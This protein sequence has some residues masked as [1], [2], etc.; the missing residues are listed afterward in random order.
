MLS[1]DDE[2]ESGGEEWKSV[3]DDSINGSDHHEQKKKIHRSDDD[4][5][6]FM[7]NYNRDQ[8]QQ[9]RKNKEDEDDDDENLDLEDEVNGNFSNILE[10][11]DNELDEEGEGEP[12]DGGEDDE[13][14]YE[15]TP[16]KSLSADDLLAMIDSNPIKNREESRSAESG[17]R[18]ASYSFDTEES[19]T[20]DSYRHR[21][22]KHSKKPKVRI[23]SDE[24][25]ESQRKRFDSEE[26]S[27]PRYRLESF[28]NPFSFDDL[29]VTLSK[30][31]PRR[32]KDVFDLD[33]DDDDDSFSFRSRKKD[34]G[35]IDSGDGIYS[36]PSDDENESRRNSVLSPQQQSTVRIP[37]VATTNETKTVPIMTVETTET[38]G[39]KTSSK[40][41]PAKPSSTVPAPLAPSVPT[42]NYFGNDEDTNSNLFPEVDHQPKITLTNSLKSLQKA[43]SV[44]VPA[45]AL[46]T[47]TTSSPSVGVSASVGVGNSNTEIERGRTESDKS[48]GRVGSDKENET[49]SPFVTTSF[50]SSHSSSITP[51]PFTHPRSTTSLSQHSPPS[52]LSD[53]II[54]DEVSSSTQQHTT[55]TSIPKGKPSPL[56]VMASQRFQNKKS[57]STKPIFTKFTEVH[58]FANAVKIVPNSEGGALVLCATADSTVR[59][60]DAVSGRILGMYEGHSDRV[61]AV[62]I[63]EKIPDHED[64]TIQYVVAGSRDE[65]VCVWNYKTRACLQVLTGHDGAVWAVAVYVSLNSPPLA[66]SGSSDCSIRSWNILTGEMQHIFKGHSDTVLSLAISHGSSYTL[67][68]DCRIIS[69]GADHMVRI[70]DMSTGRHCRMLEGHTD[71]VNA[72]AVVEDTF[73]NLFHGIKIISGGRDR[74]IRVWDIQRGA[75]IAEFPGHADCVYGVC[76]IVG[77]FETLQGIS[78]TTGNKAKS[79]T[80][81]SMKSLE[82]MTG[83]GGGGRGTVVGNVSRSQSIWIQDNHGT[84]GGGGTTSASGHTT[85]PEIFLIVSCSEDRTIKVWDVLGERLLVTSKQH[86]G[87]VKG[88]SLAPIVIPGDQLSLPSASI[89][90]AS[91][92][93]D[94]SVFFYDLDSLLVAEEKKCCTIS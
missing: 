5:D 64:D 76:G 90:L 65:T 58:S 36:D 26:F 91:C 73:G 8:G 29:D 77:N 24:S 1:D 13:L 52:L 93:W 42:V 15:L 39:K 70:W 32:N 92:S 40:Q 14:D 61:L 53:Q 41:S 55:T 10:N 19:S 62:S 80:Q 67:T 18:L 46:P 74:I 87:S 56:Q 22:R 2:R 21:H 78:T 44:V 72:V 12:G 20:S 23:N 75:Q 68:S 85:R 37:N 9:Q 3:S 69:G 45:S 48:R 51:E 71:D 79:T 66:F 38:N 43:T 30:T 47:S 4:D 86:K 59:L 57:S 94:K 25:D 63:N 17:N 28:D 7:K 6:E 27:T 82:H 33:D 34:G 81:T 60:I 89:L 54:E 35:R 16:R 31:S 49:R 11:I 84:R 50:S 83:G 88:I